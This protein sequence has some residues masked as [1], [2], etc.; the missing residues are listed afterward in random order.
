MLLKMLMLISITLSVAGCAL[1]PEKLVPLGGLDD[2][3][4]V[5]AGAKLCNVPLPTDEEGKTYCIVTSKPMQL[6]SLDAQN[7]LDKAC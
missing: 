6:R 7:R 5:P 1:I 2:V 3:I 4:D